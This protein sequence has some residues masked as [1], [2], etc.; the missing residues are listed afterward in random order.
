MIKGT[1]KTCTVSIISNLKAEG[2]GRERRLELL[3]YSILVSDNSSFPTIVLE[4]TEAP[5]VIKRLV[6]PKASLA[7]LT[8]ARNDRANRIIMGEGVSW[9]WV[10]SRGSPSRPPNKEE[11]DERREKK[12][13]RRKK[14]ILLLENERS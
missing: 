8:T 13:K 4:S 10:D 2:G 3:F 11:G 9:W 12:E 14:I 6:H 1:E 5:L 7:V